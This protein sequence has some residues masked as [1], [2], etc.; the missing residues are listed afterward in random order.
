MANK[1]NVSIL[2]FTKDELVQKLLRRFAKRA[3]NGIKEYGNTMEEAEKSIFEWIDDHQEELWDG[4]VYMEKIRA[5]L[6]ETG[7]FEFDKKH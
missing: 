4:I 7:L 3:N 1:K 6:K 5:K 2:A